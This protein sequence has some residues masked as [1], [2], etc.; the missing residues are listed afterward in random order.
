[1]SSQPHTPDVDSNVIPLRAAA[2]LRPPTMMPVAGPGGMLNVTRRA[3]EIAGF[4][5]PVHIAEPVWQRLITDVDPLLRD[6]NEHDLFW[7][8]MDAFKA[9]PWRTEH[10]LRVWLTGAPLPVTLRRVKADRFPCVLHVLPRR[11]GSN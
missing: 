6:R 9:D 2:P 1:M 10:H 5:C 4:R 3:Q 8:L 7:L 11:P